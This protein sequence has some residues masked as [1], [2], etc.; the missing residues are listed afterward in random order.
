MSETDQL[1]A[2]LPGLRGMPTQNPKQQKQ[3]AREVVDWFFKYIMP[4]SS[5]YKR[6]FEE[7]QRFHGGQQNLALNLLQMHTALA[8]G[9]IKNTGVGVAVLPKIMGLGDTEQYVVQKM[10]QNKYQAF[11]VRKDEIEAAFNKAEADATGEL[12][13]FNIKGQE[14][15][16]LEQ[17][18]VNIA[19]SIAWREAHPETFEKEEAAPEQPQIEPV[20]DKDEENVE[21]EEGEVAEEPSLEQQ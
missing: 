3:A 2:P 9:L 4:H 21:P 7:A 6:A 17:S 16:P 13:K 15:C 1:T 10:T 8:Q 5:H 14:W 20:E 19:N 18:K 11:L 12:W